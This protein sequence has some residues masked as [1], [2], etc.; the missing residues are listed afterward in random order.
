MIGP[1]RGIDDNR[2]MKPRTLSKSRFKLALECP[3]KVFYSLDRRYVNTKNEDEFLQALADGGFQVGELAK[4]MYAA[5]DPAAVEVTA[6]DQDEQVRQTTELLAR[7]D[8]TVF[9]GTIRHGN[10]LARVDVLRK[11]GNVVELIEVKSKSFDP[12]REDHSFRG[13]R[14]EIRSTWLPYL[15]D[16]AFQTCVCRQA[17]P[18]LEVR[19]FLLLVDP[20]QTC[21]VDGL[22]TAI[23]VDRDADNRA[24]VTVAPALDVR[25]ISPPVLTLHDVAE[26][27][28][29]ILAGLV[30]TPVGTFGFAE[31]AEWMAAGSWPVGK[32]SAGGCAVQE[33]RVLL[34]SG[35]S[36]GGQAQRLGGVHGG[37]VSGSGRGCRAPRRCLGSTTTGRKG[38]SSRTGQAAAHRSRR[39]RRRGGGVRRRNRAASS[40]PA[41]DPGSARRRRG[42][43]AANENTARGVCRLDVSAALHRLRDVAAD[44]AVHGGSAAEPAAAVPVLAP[45]DR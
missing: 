15:Q 41:A 38:T 28:D 35:R 23:R 14:G 29:E 33:M 45:R 3:T 9:E 12:N 17:S 34:R 10:L 18:G 2:S 22:G 37:A 16:V 13:K 36:H 8:V 6:R 43:P 30:K 25:A 39:G 40:T 20:T 31:F 44:A 24:V 32:S 42:D 1:H 5:E 11:R 27:V 4:A 21:S 19:P 7:P 26:F